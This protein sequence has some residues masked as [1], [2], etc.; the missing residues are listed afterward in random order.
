VKAQRLHELYA[1]VRNDPFWRVSG[2]GGVFVPGRGSLEDGRLVLV[3]EAPGREEERLQ[4]PFV[5]AAGRNLTRL[6][7]EIGLAREKVFITNLMKY[8]P[9]T[10]KGGNRSPTAREQRHALPYLTEELKILSP[11]LVVCLGLPA[12]RALL[13]DPGLRMG[14][15]NGVLFQVHP[16]QVFVTYHPSPL[17]YF[18]PVK[19]EALHA[20]FS[21][22]KSLLAAR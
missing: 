6:L 18:T 17:N 1:R 13:D 2:V 5:G 12:A 16:F 14:A 19:R 8:R 15:S 3:G 11:G 22:I 4:Q 10:P 20:A 9:L 7:E 21:R